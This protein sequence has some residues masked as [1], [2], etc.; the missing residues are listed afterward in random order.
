MASQ[1][2]NERENDLFQKLAS[3]GISFIVEN[4]M[5]DLGFPKTPDALLSVPVG[6]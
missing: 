1:Q 6:K 2:G 3:L 4:G 5:R